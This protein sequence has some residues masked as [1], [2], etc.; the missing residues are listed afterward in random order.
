MNVVIEGCNEYDVKAVT[1]K[2]LRISKIWHFFDLLRIKT[3]ILL[4]KKFKKILKQAVPVTVRITQIL[5]N[6]HLIFVLYDRFE[7]FYRWVGKGWGRAGG[8]ICS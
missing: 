3:I 6:F 4:K 7:F 2:L 8:V 1:C 5:Y